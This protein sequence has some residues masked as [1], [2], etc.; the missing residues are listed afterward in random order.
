MANSDK[1]T[2]MNDVLLISLLVL[3]CL[4][5]VVLTAVR[6]P[7]TWL[8]VVSAA[9]YAWS[10]EWARASLTLLAILI[11]LALF[12]EGIELFASIITAR[13]AGASRKAAWG[14]ML[15]GILGMIFLSFLVPIPFVGT[16]IGALLGCFLGA[17]LVEMSVRRDMS[18]GTKVGFFAAMGFVVGSVTKTFI[19]LLMSGIL[20]V[21]VI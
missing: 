21:K 19:A 13:R 15:G 2:D 7:G 3:V 1:R 16:V 17:T 10:E 11:G 5:G 6:L 18:H 12:G 4:I 9:G 20:L 14:G 8:I